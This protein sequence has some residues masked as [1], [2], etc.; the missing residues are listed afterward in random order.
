MYKRIIVGALFT[1][2]SLTAHSHPGPNFDYLS[3]DYKINKT[4][5][6][7]KYDSTSIVLSSEIGKNW[8]A[9]INI[10]ESEDDITIDDETFKQD[11]SG[12]G[13]NLGYQMKMGNHSTMYSLIKYQKADTMLFVM[14][15]DNVL[16]GDGS[17]VGFGVGYAHRFQ[18][19]QAD[20]F[21]GVSKDKTLDETE[22]VGNIEFQY[23]FNK[24][25]TLGIHAGVGIDTNNAGIRA[26]YHF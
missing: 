6:D 11:L 22:M 1:T 18:H 25:F 21:V 8:L 9:Q 4:S 5:F 7:E 2:F 24:H 3:V 20:G 23:F 17:Q 26:K 10:T 15:S 14:D 16:I 19:W 13:V 12:F